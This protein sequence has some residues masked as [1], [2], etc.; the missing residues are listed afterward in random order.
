VCVNPAEFLYA[1]A[2]E[3]RAVYVSKSV[4]PVLFVTMKV[5]E[6]QPGGVDVP[7]YKRGDVIPLRRWVDPAL[8]N[9]IWTYV[10]PKGIPRPRVRMFKADPRVEAGKSDNP[11]GGG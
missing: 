10:P 8:I 6:A 2:Q 7:G 11:Y 5:I 9:S 1:M 3:F 4:N